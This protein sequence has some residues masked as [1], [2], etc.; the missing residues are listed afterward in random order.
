MDNTESLVQLPVA[1][2]PAGEDPL[3]LLAD[4]HLPPEIGLW[5]LA[6][7]WWVLVVLLLAGGFWL[8]LVLLRKWQQQRRLNAALKA[9]QDCFTSYQTALQQSPET[10]IDTLK[11]LLVNDVNQVL[12]R[13]AL[14]RFPGQAVAGLSGES[15][16]N[17]IDG[18][19]PGIVIAEDIRYALAQGRFAP[20]CTIDPPAL[21]SMARDWIKQC[22]LSKI[23]TGSDSLKLATK[24]A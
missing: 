21:Q 8:S 16:V 20:R 13:V 10:E 14:I 4:I 2:A 6:P 24:H 22:Y 5:P 1:Q 15:W 7:G 23:R 19:S 9:L 11:S 17:F 3:S 18:V 12:R